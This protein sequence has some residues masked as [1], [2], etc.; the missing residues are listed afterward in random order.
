MAWIS[1]SLMNRERDY[2]IALFA[3]T[4]S[5]S[6]TTMAM[7]LMGMILLPFAPHFPTGEKTL[8]VVRHVH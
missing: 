6:M 5:V 7:L 1:F 3:L 8:E 2:A 4:L